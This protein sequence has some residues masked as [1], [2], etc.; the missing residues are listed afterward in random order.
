MAKIFF[1][2]GKEFDTYTNQSIA[3]KRE[4]SSVG[5]PIEVRTINIKTKAALGTLAED[6]LAAVDTKL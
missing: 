4:T 1:F 2:L 6:M 5:Q 3:N